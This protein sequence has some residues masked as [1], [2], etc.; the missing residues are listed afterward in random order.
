MPLSGRP[1]AWPNPRFVDGVRATP[2]PREREA[3]TDEGES[4][5]GSAY[6]LQP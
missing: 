2:L 1:T 5:D 6:S 3:L 4:R